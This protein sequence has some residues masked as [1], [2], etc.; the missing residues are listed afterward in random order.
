M[1][2]RVVEKIKGGKFCGDGS[3]IICQ[4]GKRLDCTNLAL[5][6]ETWGEKKGLK[7]QKT[8]RRQ[9]NLKSYLDEGGE[10]RKKPAFL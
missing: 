3:A 2:G 7:S 9:V 10:V 1:F 5:S 8:F 4:G 6:E